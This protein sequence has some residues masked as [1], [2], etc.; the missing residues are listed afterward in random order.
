MVADVTAL[1]ELTVR[2]YSVPTDF[3]E[4]DGTLAWDKTIL[5]LVNANAGGK[6]GVGFTYANAATAELIKEVLIP[7]VQGADVMNV[8]ASWAADAP[9]NS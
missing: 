6:V 9:R 5:V 2:A 4:S 8:P 3:P 1:R 7:L